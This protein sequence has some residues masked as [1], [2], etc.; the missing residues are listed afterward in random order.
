MNT[1]CFIFL[2]GEYIFFQHSSLS[3]VI[4]FLKTDPKANEDPIV[5][6]ISHGSLIIY[7]LT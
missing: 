3:L 2:K 7:G 5:I 6:L 1:T 4:S